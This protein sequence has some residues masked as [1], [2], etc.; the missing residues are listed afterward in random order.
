LG[1]LRLGSENESLP[2]FVTISPPRAHGGAQNYS[3]AFLPASYQ[4][5][6]IGS[7]DVPM[8]Q[9]EIPFLKNGDFSARQQRRQLDLIQA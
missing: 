2:G 9:A 5:T 7:A 8:G 6:P 3:S 4:G 1:H